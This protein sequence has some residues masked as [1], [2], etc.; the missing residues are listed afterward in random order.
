MTRR[1]WGLGPDGKP[2]PWP[3][4]V[5]QLPK[6]KLAERM[7]RR[8]EAWLTV[9]VPAVWEP[10]RGTGFPHWDAWLADRPEK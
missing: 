3:T 4:P 8:V 10:H 2:L 7:A 9:P 6:P 1:S 5:P